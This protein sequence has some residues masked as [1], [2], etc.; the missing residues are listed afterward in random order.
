[1]SKLP[2]CFKGFSDHDPAGAEA[3]CAELW[4]TCAEAAGVELPQ[5][6]ML[7]NSVIHEGYEGPSCIGQLHLCGMS[8]SEA[9][10]KVCE[11]IRSVRD[12]H[13]Y[14]PDADDFHCGCDE[15]DVEAFGHAYMCPQN[16]NYE[17]PPNM[18][19]DAS[20]IRSDVFRWYRD[21]YG[22]WP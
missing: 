4:E 12:V 22:G 11:A 9:L 21:I 15:Q 6:R 5:L 16:P 13:Y 19:I 10:E 18:C 1:M 8:F 17:P 2:D 3:A 14:D 7:I 20:E